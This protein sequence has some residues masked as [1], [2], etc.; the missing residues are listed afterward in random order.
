MSPT[1]TT[2]RSKTAAMFQ[3]AGRDIRD[4]CQSPTKASAPVISMN[5]SASIAA[6]SCR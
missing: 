2:E 6:P 1:V 3:R 5:V 4:D